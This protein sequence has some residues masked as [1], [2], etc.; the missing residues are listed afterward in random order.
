MKSTK[1]KYFS[2]EKKGEEEE[3]DED[4]KKTEKGDTNEDEKLHK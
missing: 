4:L 1:E 2:A 3:E